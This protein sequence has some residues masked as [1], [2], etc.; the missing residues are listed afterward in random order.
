VLVR[1]HPDHPKKPQIVLID[2]GLYIPLS[3]EFRHDYCLL[4]RSLFVADLSTIERIAQKWGIAKENSDMFA[5]MTLLRPH[6]LRQKAQIVENNGA[7]KD[8][9]KYQ[10]QTGLKDR[11]RSMLENEQLIPRVSEPEN[12]K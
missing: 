3:E 4:W 9:S 7:G 1:P 5:S 12:E 6:R 8:L 10:A 2:H 11:L